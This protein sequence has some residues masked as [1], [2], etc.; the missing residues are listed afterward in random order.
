MEEIDKIMEFLPINYKNSNDLNYINAL[1]N[2]IY[3]VLSMY[4]DSKADEDD[5]YNNVIMFNNCILDVTLIYVYI[6]QTIVIRLYIENKN[7]IFK[8]YNHFINKDFFNGSFKND[9]Q[10][11]M[12]IIRNSMLENDGL[13]NFITFYIKNSNL[14][15]DCNNV[16][17]KIKDKHNEVFK[18]RNQIAHMNAELYKYDNFLKLCKN[19]VES[20]IYLYN[21]LFYPRDLKRKELIDNSKFFKDLNKYVEKELIDINNYD[22]YIEEINKSYLLTKY[23]YRKFKQYIN[24]INN[25]QIKKYLEMYLEKCKNY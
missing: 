24:K 17:K 3:S 9:F 14:I 13:I 25:E 4:N 8:F 1:L 16:I 22:I 5:Q 10:I 23:D 19:I 21:I 7:D 11:S 2:D 15:S 20:L 18:L 6:V 12:E